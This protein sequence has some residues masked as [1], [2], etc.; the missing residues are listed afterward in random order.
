MAWCASSPGSAE[1]ARVH[2][3]VRRIF[4]RHIVPGLPGFRFSEFPSTPIFLFFAP[5]HPPYSGFTLR[6]A[7]ANQTA[8]A[9]AR[10]RKNVWLDAKTRG[11]FATC[12]FYNKNV[13]IL[14]CT[15][16]AVVV[17]A[18]GLSASTPH[19]HPLSFC[20]V[21]VTPLAG[22]SLDPACSISR[23]TALT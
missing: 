18:T 14:V 3:A 5:A 17:G 8:A 11:I 16:T 23:S 9:L 7:S 20:A 21:N 10:M 19:A 13:K 1:N 4:R 2:V 22:T 15:R 12:C 6:L